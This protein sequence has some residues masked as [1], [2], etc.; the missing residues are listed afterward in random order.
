MPPPLST[1]HKIHHKK[2]KKEEVN[3]LYFIFIY[4]ILFIYFFFLR[5]PQKR[6]SHRYSNSG[7]LTGKKN[8]TKKNDR[9]DYFLMFPFPF[10]SS[11]RRQV[12]FS[13]RAF[14]QQQQQQRKNDKSQQ[15][16]LII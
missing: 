13:R 2:K 7:V 6:V 15:R 14:K 16:S 10:L 8:K 12:Q 4:F 5:F 3:F 11:L 1:A 9:D